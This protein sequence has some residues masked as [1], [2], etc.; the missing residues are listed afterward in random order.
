[1][2][3]WPPERIKASLATRVQEAAVQQVTQAAQKEQAA[4]LRPYDARIGLTT[5]FRCVLTEQAALTV[6]VSSVRIGKA[7]TLGRRKAEATIPNIAPRFR[8]SKT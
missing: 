3:R 6:G 7:R 2:R 4:R 1:M 8:L 5:F